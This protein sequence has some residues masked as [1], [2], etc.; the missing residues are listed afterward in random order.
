MR[1]DEIIKLI[2]NGFIGNYM[3]LTENVEPPAQFHFLV[4]MTLLGTALG[5]KVSMN[6]G[7]FQIYPNIYAALIAPTGRCRKSTALQIGVKILRDAGLDNVKTIGPQI[8]PEALVKSARRERAEYDEKENK[9]VPVYPDSVNLIYVPELAVFLDKRDYNAGMVPLL[10]DLFDCPDDW[11]ST[12][13]GRGEQK[14]KNVFISTLFAST[15]NWLRQL[16]PRSA[17]AGGFM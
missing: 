14:L 3:K 2:P 8:T 10:T 4:A 5:R 16:L 17:F 6:M 11:A 13:I 12:T 15:P 7:M 9:V 1:D